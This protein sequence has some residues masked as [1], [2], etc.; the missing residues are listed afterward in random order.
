MIINCEALI[1][2][3]LSHNLSVKKLLDNDLNFVKIVG[4]GSARKRPLSVYGQLE[5]HL[6]VLSMKV[7]EPERYG[8]TVVTKDDLWHK[9]TRS[10]V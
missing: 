8:M 9:D 10:F 2:S 1:V 5:E 6:Y 7:V 3:N 4:F